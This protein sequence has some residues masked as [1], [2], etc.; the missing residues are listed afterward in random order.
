MDTGCFVWRSIW[1]R[2]F[3]PRSATASRASG[4]TTHLE[5]ELVPEAVE[6]HVVDD[7][8]SSVAATAVSILSASSADRI[9]TGGVH[10]DRRQAGH[11]AVGRGDARHRWIGVPRI[12]AAPIRLSLTEGSVDRATSAAFIDVDRQVGPG[13]DQT[14]RCRRGD[15]AVAQRHGQREGEPAAGRITDDDC[16]FRVDPVL[17]QS[18]VDQRPSLRGRPDIAP[19]VRVSSRG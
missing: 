2:S 12:D 8:R 4:S 13:A 1:L 9:V 19:P 6:P 3:A 17:E 7:G 16:A 11:V 15:P 5:V 10:D 14:E 18:G